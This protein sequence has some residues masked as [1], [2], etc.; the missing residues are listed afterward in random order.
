MVFINQSGFVGDVFS[1]FTTYISGSTFL[2]LLCIT[3]LV[4]GL[5]SMFRVP[6]EAT[7]I[8]VLPMMLVFMAWS[9]G[10]YLAM[11]GVVLML[12]GIMVAKSWVVR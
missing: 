6:I 7:L 1:G 3:I 9:S 10:G 12:V 11:G 5:F 2:T 8:L 4:I